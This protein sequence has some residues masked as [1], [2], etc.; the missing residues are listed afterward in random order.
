MEFV[1]LHQPLLHQVLDILHQHPGA[2][3][4]LN[5]VD[6]RVDAVLGQPLIGGYL[7][8]GLLYGTDDLTPV[9]IDDVSVS[10]DYFHGAHSSQVFCLV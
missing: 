8:I 7:C 6:H 10:L 3:E 1:L 9:V 5:A 2:F 4:G